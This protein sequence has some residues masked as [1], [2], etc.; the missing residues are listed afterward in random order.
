MP[1]IFNF[2]GFIVAA[3]IAYCKVIW[4]APMKTIWITTLV[5]MESENGIICIYIALSTTHVIVYKCLPQ[6]IV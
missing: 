5:A 3:E 1:T 6:L 2:F 4:V